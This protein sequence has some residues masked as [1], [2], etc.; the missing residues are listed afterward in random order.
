L[1]FLNGM[2][3]TAEEKRICQQPIALGESFL[4]QNRLNVL[5]PHAC[6]FQHSSVNPFRAKN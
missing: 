2:I 4:F 3:T 1:L 5:K 6:R